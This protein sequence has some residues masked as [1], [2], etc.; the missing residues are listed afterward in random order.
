MLSVVGNQNGKSNK[1]HGGYDRV[2][3]GKLTCIVLIRQIKHVCKPK[4]HLD[5]THL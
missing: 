5:D 4:C 1:S 3:Q 2:D